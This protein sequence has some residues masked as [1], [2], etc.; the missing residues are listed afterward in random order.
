MKVALDKKN[1]YLMRM[2]ISGV[3]S[4]NLPADQYMPLLEHADLGFSYSQVIA[5]GVTCCC[6]SK[7]SAV[8][9]VQNLVGL[10]LSLLKQFPVYLITSSLPYFSVLLSKKATESNTVT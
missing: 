8:L 2:E 7:Y 10:V 5:E 6:L 3:L 1:S 9:V 4:S